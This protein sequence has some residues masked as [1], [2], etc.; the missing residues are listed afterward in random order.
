MLT[1]VWNAPSSARFA[2][3]FLQPLHIAALAKQTW[4]DKNVNKSIKDK[5]LDRCG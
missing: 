5:T 2:D 1:A 4:G 3:S